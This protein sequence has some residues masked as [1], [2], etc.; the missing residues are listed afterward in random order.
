MSVGK[1][2]S[3]LVHVHEDHVIAGSQDGVELL[4]PHS[5]KL[6]YVPRVTLVQGD[7]DHT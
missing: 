4:V 1:L 7:V 2:T 6:S 5:W 3:W